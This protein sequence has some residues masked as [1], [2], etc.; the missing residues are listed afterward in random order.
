MHG[1][2][3]PS[4][5]KLAAICGKAAKLTRFTLLAGLD[6]F[7][8]IEIKKPRASSIDLEK[9]YKQFETLDFS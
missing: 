4:N 8:A 5:G 9:E 1:S 2:I 6:F 7:T 3:S